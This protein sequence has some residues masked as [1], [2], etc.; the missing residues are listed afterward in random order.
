MFALDVI[1]TILVSCAKEFFKLTFLLGTLNM[2]ALT[3]VN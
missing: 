3:F 2:A 1:V